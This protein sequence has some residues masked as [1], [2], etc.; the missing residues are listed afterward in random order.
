MR[1]KTRKSIIQTQSNCLAGGY[2][3]A[4]IAI[5]IIISN[6]G[7]GWNEVCTMKAAF[8]ILAAISVCS[9]ARTAKMMVILVLVYIN[10]LNISSAVIISRI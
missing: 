10:N 8:R 3:C 9:W 2:K 7:K 1:P 4:I 6:I 5:N